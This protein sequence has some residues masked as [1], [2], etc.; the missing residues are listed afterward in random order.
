MGIGA[1]LVTG[2]SS[3]AVSGGRM[4][5]EMGAECAFN[6]VP[7]MAEERKKVGFAVSCFGR[8]NT[9]YHIP[10]LLSRSY[11]AMGVFFIFP[12][13]YP[14]SFPSSTHL[15]GYIFPFLLSA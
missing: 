12:D 5:D 6:P 8:R 15:G 1:H 11:S 2:Q 3:Q 13:T 9:L 7:M 10:G 14:I 4:D